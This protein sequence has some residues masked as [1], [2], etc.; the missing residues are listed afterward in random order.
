MTVIRSADPY[1]AEEVMIPREPARE[2]TVV[3][4]D[5]GGPPLGI[6]RWI[7]ARE[8]WE[9]DVDHLARVQGRRWWSWSAIVGHA[10]RSDKRLYTRPPGWTP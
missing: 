3:L 8:A 6:W 4:A 9:V 1:L 2:R 5:P 7:P 10:I